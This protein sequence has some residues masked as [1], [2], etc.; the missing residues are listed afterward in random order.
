MVYREIDDTKG[1]A[2]F[3]NIH[4]YLDISQRYEDIRKEKNIS[5]IIGIAGAVRTGLSGYMQ[6]L[7]EKTDT[8]RGVPLENDMI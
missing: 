5:I 6:G 2:S 8:K 7:I 4:K 1:K 3:I